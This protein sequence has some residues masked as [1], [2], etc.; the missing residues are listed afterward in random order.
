[1]EPKTRLTDKTVATDTIWNGYPALTAQEYWKNAIETWAD[2]V[3]M[4]SGDVRRMQMRT[5]IPLIL[6][7]AVTGAAGAREKPVTN[8]IH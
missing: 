2:D 5:A 7:L 6:T 8:K 1:M 3:G 4:L